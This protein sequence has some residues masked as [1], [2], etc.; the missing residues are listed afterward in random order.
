MATW[1][2]S[3]NR[4]GCNT[5][6]ISRSSK[7]W[8][9]SSPAFRRLQLQQSLPPSQKVVTALTENSGPSRCAGTST[10]SAA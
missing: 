1:G 7:R 5:V 8:D 2:D 6:E 3:E 9:R 4:R 10:P